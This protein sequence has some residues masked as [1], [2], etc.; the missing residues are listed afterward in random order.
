MI[1]EKAILKLCPSL[2]PNRDFFVGADP[3][4]LEQSI[5]NWCCDMPQPTTEELQSAWK[6]YET[7]MELKKIDTDKQ[8]EIE[9]LKK[10]LQ[11]TDFYYVRQL[12]SG[13]PVP[14]LIR[15]KRLATRQRLNDLGL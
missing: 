7:D 14:D 3:D 13:K 12:E 1:L 15:Q 2:V 6:Q 8:D 10:Y 11:A 5:D 9:S 4:T